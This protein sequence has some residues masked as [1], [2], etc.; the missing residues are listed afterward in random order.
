MSNPLFGSKAGH[1]PFSSFFSKST[2]IWKN[3]EITDT[4]IKNI[5]KSIDLFYQAGNSVFPNLSIITISL[6]YQNLCNITH[7]DN[8]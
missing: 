1:L 4:A 8:K 3:Y 6:V 2:F 7:F 5:N